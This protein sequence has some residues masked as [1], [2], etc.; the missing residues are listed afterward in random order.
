MKIVTLFPRN[1]AYLQLINIY[2]KEIKQCMQN[3]W[4]LKVDTYFDKK[5]AQ[6]VQLS[7]TPS[8]MSVTFTI[9]DGF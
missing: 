2:S 3:Q 7:V 9:L 6:N 5:G 1:S 4:P 8:K